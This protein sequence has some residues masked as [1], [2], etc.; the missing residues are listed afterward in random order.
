MSP[1]NI[2]ISL[3]ETLRSSLRAAPH[4]LWLAGPLLLI[5]AIPVADAFLPPDIHLAHL[6]VVAVAVTAVAFGPWLTAL[7]GALAVLAL[8]AAGTLRHSLTTESVVVEIAD[9]VA[10]C[11][12]LVFFTYLR[13][14]RDRELVHVHS[15]SDATQ[16]G[17]RCRA[18]RLRCTR[19]S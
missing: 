6:L 5:F 13:G 2:T 18:F 7:V 1:A 11:A 16:R 19:R 3:A 12:F 14:G 17:R 9:L 10:V 8:V 15:V 4:W